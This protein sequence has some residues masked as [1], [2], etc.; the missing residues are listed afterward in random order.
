M[1]IDTFRKIHRPRHGVKGVTGH[2]RRCMH[3]TDWATISAERVR[4]GFILEV[5]YCD[6]HA[7]AR[8]VTP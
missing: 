1:S 3:C 7:E 5:R 4:Y 8:G 6:V 2:K